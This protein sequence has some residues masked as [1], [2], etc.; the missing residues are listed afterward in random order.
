MV[1]D[2]LLKLANETGLRQGG[3]HVP[4]APIYSL[5]LRIGPVILKTIFRISTRGTERLAKRGPVIIAGNHVSHV[6]PILMIVGARRTVRFL[7]KAEHFNNWFTRFVMITTGQLET[8]RET[9]GKEGIAQAVEVLEKGGMM[10]IFPEGTRSKKENP[11][12]LQR[13]KTGVARLA[14]TFPDVPVHPIALLGAREMLTPGS[15]KFRRRSPLTMSV[16]QS[17]TWREWITH[18]NGGNM[19]D[20]ALKDLISSEEETRKEHL[21]VLY[22]RF[23]DQLMGS[24]QALGAP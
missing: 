10:G 18:P 8:R 3:S 19:D 9:G 24:I 17:V 4:P 7:S 14:A 2:P 20:D 6:D 15:S 5:L 11:P 12:Y 22:R 1:G 13:G 16:G 21:A 23:T